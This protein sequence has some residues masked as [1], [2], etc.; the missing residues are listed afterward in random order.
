MAAELRL[1]RWGCT[2][3]DV[4]TWSL[5]KLGMYI[6]EIDALAVNEMNLFAIAQHCPEKLA[7]MG[8]RTGPAPAEGDT[9]RSAEEWRAQ[10]E[11]E[12][13]L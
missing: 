7:G 1:A 5:P 13:M 2:L 4:R 12:G 11:R 9:P 10:M 6:A 8:G 3:A